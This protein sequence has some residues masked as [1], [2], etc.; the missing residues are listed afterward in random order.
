MHAAL[1]LSDELIDELLAADTLVFGVPMYNFG[2]SAGFK[3]Y[4]DQIVRVGRTFSYPGFEG[5]AKGKRAVVMVAAGQ[6]YSEGAPMAAMDYVTPYLRTVLGFVGI[7]DVTFIAVAT[8]AGEE[9]LARTLES[10]RASVQA[11]AARATVGSAT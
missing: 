4:I 3:A 9:T 8:N 1:R 11:V 6:E 5:L 7:T 2:L 10:A